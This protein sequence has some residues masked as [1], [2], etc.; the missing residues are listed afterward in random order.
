MQ[1]QMLCWC[2]MHAGLRAEAA[3][4]QLAASEA[5]AQARSEQRAADTVRK[6]SLQFG[7]CASVLFTTLIKL[8]W[9][10]HAGRLNAV[11]S[12]SCA[13]RAVR[14]ELCCACCAAAPGADGAGGV[15]G[16]KRGAAAR[17][18]GGTARAGRHPAGSA[19][20]ASTSGGGAAQKHGL[21]CS[22]LG[23]R[24]A[25]SHAEQQD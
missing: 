14:P 3:Q 8:A 9:L 24:C 6:V 19:H 16:C 22:Q 25:M 1:R 4:A 5:A 12:L 13:A 2:C 10:P 15:P 17:G 23:S 18:M 11:R 7:L 21:Y 20:T